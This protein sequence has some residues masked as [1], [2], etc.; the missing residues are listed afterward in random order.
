MLE[1][2][3]K[4]KLFCNLVVA[5][6]TTRVVV[7]ATHSHG[8]QIIAIID[9]WG[10]VWPDHSDHEVDAVVWLALDESVQEQLFDEAERLFASVDVYWKSEMSRPKK[11]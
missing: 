6:S 9:P 11:V 5:K 8:H 10:H 2:T 7:V 3:V 1:A 4:L